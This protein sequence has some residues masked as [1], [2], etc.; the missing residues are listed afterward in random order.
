VASPRR[1]RYSSPAPT[2]RGPGPAPRRAPRGDGRVPAR[3]ARRRAL[4]QNFLTDAS[5]ARAVVRAADLSPDGLVVEVGA[6]AG[7]LTRHL[8]PAC[9]RLIAYEVDPDLAARLAARHGDRVRVVRADFRTAVPPRSPFAVVGNI[10]YAITAPV[11]DWCLSAR[12]LTGAT[13]ITQLEYARKRTGGFGRWSR[14][15]VR[16]WPVFSWRMGRRIPRERFD[17]VPR[18]DS[19]VL[20]L[21]RRAAPLIAPDRLAA[22]GHLV[23]LGFTG[24][25]GT[26]RASLRRAHPA[27]RVDAALAA[28]GVDRS[29]VVAYV[30][31]DQWVRLAARLLEAPPRSRG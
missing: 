21:R 10:P 19:A 4:S 11:V 18:V 3:G 30:T 14:L 28:A 24:V 23:D 17:P 26:L 1:P 5:V 2:D 27:H 29:A 16:T 7:M 25:G 31:P 13:L 12:R 8:A 15:T 22:Y 6:G 9:G 20:L